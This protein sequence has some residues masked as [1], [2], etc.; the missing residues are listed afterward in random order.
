MSHWQGQGRTSISVFEAT[1]A[2]GT[3]RL[4]ALKLLVKSVCVLAALIAIGVS[5]W[6][7]L[8]LLGDAVFIQVWSVPLDSQRSVIKAA[9][10]ALTVYEQLSLLVVAAVA[11][12]IWV[13]TFA[14]L[15][16]LWTRYSRRMNIAVLL[17][18]LYGV[19]LGLLAL[20]GQRGIGPEIP[21]GA[22]LQATS[23]VAP[24]AIVL[25][26]GYLLWRGFAE[27]LLT[28]RQACGAVLV[29]AAFGAAWLTMLRAA[30]VSLAG[31]PTTNYVWMLSPA[32]LP[33]FASVLTPW[34]LS[35]IRHT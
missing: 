28:P 8:P 2:F 30:G 18:L 7:S 19:V 3:A 29:S 25:A 10:A 17:L 4:A 16:A 9:V 31:T 13:A 32:L 24:S 20:T 14:A 26:T 34:S 15:G 1:Q 6:I 11:V 5:I 33:L 23:W 21:L 22:V 27:Q 35:R 12:V